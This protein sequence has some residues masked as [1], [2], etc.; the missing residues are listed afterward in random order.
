VVILADLAESAFELELEQVEAARERAAKMLSEGLPPEQNREAA[1][2]L[3][4]AD[5]ALRIKHKM[6]SRGPVMRIVEE[7]TEG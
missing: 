4:R 1:L 5:I 2:A 6:Q 3:R 7:E